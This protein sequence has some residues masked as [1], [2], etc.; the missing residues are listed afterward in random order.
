MPLLVYANYFSYH[1]TINKN[2]LVV[3]S[4]GNAGTQ[5]DSYPASFKYAFSV[6]NTQS[7]DALNSSS[8][9]GYNV[10]VCAPGTSIYATVPGGYQAQTGTSMA[11]PCVAGAAGI[12]KAFYP[13]Y[14]GMQGGDLKS[15]I[16]LNEDITGRTVIILED[17]IEKK[18]AEFTWLK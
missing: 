15:L 1:T 11:A 4:A 13:S 17:I 10:D 3:V 2:C 7:N 12:V 14:N 8:Q 6:A 16:G 18:L 5:D 9:Y